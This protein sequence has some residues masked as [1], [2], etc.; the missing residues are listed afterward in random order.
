M[1]Q[2]A[3]PSLFC[4]VGARQ[5]P[6]FLPSCH[7]AGADYRAVAIGSWGPSLLLGDAEGTLVHWDTGEGQWLG[8]WCRQAG[9]HDLKVDVREETF[10]V[11]EQNEEGIVA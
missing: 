4:T 10:Q 5:Q 8:P 2:W 7:A 3:W 1:P 6:P 9:P 11:A